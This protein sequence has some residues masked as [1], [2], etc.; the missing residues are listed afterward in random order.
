LKYKAKAKKTL[1]Q[2][3]PVSEDPWLKK[4]LETNKNISDV[5]NR[6]NIF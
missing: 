4:A 2:I 1:P 6:S 5:R 3:H